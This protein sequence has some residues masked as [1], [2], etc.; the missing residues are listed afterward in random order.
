MS[1][2]YYRNNDVISGESD[3]ENIYT[4]KNFPVF[5]G[6]SDES[7]ENDKLVDLNFQISKSTG[8]VQINP[9]IDL[10]VVYHKSHHPGTVGQIWKRHHEE[11]ASFLL[12]FDKKDVLEIG[13]YSG[14][15]AKNC[16]SV[17][18]DINWTIIDPHVEKM[19]ERINIINAFFDDNYT[20]TTEYDLIVHSHLIEH[21]IDINSFLSNCHKRLNENGYMI[22]SL[23]NFDL[24]LEKRITNCLHFEHTFHIDEYFL[25]MMFKKHGFSLIDKTY[26][27]DGY[28]VFYCVQK[29]TPEEVIF[30]ESKYNHY[31]QAYSDYF[32]DIKKFIERFNNTDYSNKNIFMFGGHVTSQFLISLGLDQSKI[33][34]LLDNDPNKQGK[35][36]YGTSLKIESPSILKDIENPLLILKN[37]FF[38]EEIKN[39]VESIN[40]QVKIITF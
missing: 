15:L 28:N 35:R 25:S 2:I 36:L 23:P 29:T 11:L 31:K 1:L 39:Q 3:L 34:C 40:N 5:M 13:G 12:K 16:L 30:Q 32:K 7:Q 22:F 37:S 18:P 38:D 8:M 9:L 33:K 17:N 21:I 10:S 24:F 27:L 14:I 6:A 26:F 20:D 19:H 4:I